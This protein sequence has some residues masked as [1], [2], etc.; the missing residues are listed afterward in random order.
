MDWM[1]L[2]RARF[3]LPHEPTFQI[4]VFAGKPYTGFSDGQ[5]TLPYGS[6]SLVLERLKNFA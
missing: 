4:L 3:G 5:P 6:I 2:S 1:W